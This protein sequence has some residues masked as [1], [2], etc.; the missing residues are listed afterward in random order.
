MSK[1]VSKKTTQVDYLENMKPN[2]SVVPERSV[3]L[4]F[5]QQYSMSYMILKK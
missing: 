4:I 2:V 3:S 1:R 5:T